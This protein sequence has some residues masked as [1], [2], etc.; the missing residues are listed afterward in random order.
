MENQIKTVWDLLAAS[1]R[2]RLLAVGI[3]SH[4]ISI[5]I[6]KNTKAGKRKNQL[7]EVIRIIDPPAEKSV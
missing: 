2:L 5:S 6:I 3:T 1:R 7:T 4:R